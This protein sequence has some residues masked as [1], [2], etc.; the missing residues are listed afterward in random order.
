[1]MSLRARLGALVVVP[2]VLLVASAAF[3]RAGDTA[4]EIDFRKTV[5]LSPQETVQQSRDYQA[6]MQDTLKRINVLQDRAKKDKDVIKLNCVSD[7]LVQVKGH[8][9]VTDQSMTA[10]QTAIARS[11]EGGRQHEFTRITILYQ[12]VLVLGTEA[13]GCI[14]EDVSYVGSTRVD[15]DVDPN[16]P[17]EDPT[18]PTLPL[19]DVTRPPEASPFA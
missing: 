3:G 6:K 13:E 12:K 8:L 9:A 17:Q 15:V 2:G 11:D 19:P 18:E 16:V 10:L 7:K 5:S 4:A 1:M 14:G